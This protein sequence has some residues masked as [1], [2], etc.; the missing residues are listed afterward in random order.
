MGERELEFSVEYWRDRA[1]FFEDVLNDMKAHK[2]ELRDSFIERLENE[3]A[4]LKGILIKFTEAITAQLKNR[5]DEVIPKDSD[6]ASY[7]KAYQSRRIRIEDLNLSAR[8]AG[9]LI[10]GEG[11]KTLGQLCRYTESD[12]LRLPN[13]GRRSL[14]EIKEILYAH[15]LSLKPNIWR[16]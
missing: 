11:L 4:E 15:G 9:V 16:D 14:N 5:T 1:N 3:N 10:R 13:F 7:V 8:C 12:L 6:A 2:I